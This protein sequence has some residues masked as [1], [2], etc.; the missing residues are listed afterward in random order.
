MSFK[1]WLSRGDKSSKKKSALEEGKA[2]N[3]NN[4]GR[5][6]DVKNGFTSEVPSGSESQIESFVVATDTPVVNSN[7]GNPENSSVSEASDNHLHI[8]HY[9]MHSDSGYNSNASAH[10][11]DSSFKHMDHSDESDL[12]SLFHQFPTI[13]PVSTVLYPFGDGS[14]KVFGYENFGNTCYC[15]SVLQCLYSLPELR[16]NMLKHP[17]RPSNI[18]R[19]RK[20]QMIGLKPRV[21]DETSFGPVNNATTANSGSTTLPNGSSKNPSTSSG[22]TASLQKENSKKNSLTFF[23]EKELPKLP[24]TSSNSAVVHSSMPPIATPVHVNVMA[25]DAITEKLHEGYT[26]IVVGRVPG[27]PLQVNGS[28]HHT[29]NSST[30]P[31]SSPSPSPTDNSHSDLSAKHEEPSSEQRKK[32]ALLKGPVLNVDHSLADYLPANNSPSLYAELKDLFEIITENNSLTGVV[33]PIQFVETLKKEN[34]LFNTMM[35]QDAHEFLNFLLNELSDSLTKSSEK[36]SSA[37]P[38]S[39]ANFIE[40]LF[41]GTMTNRTKCLTCDNVTYRNEP[42]LDFPIEVQ[43]DSETDI[44]MILSDFHQ[45]EM[46][47]GSNK[48]YCDECCGLQEAERVVGL[49]QL[50]FYLALHLKRFKYSEE[51]NCNIKLFNKIHYPAYLKVCSTFDSTVCKQYELV[52]VIVHM[53]GGPHHGHY[54]SLCKHEKFGWLLFDDETVESVTEGT[55]LKFIGDRDDLTTAYLLF[56]KDMGSKLLSDTETHKQQK[57]AQNIDDLIKADEQIRKRSIAT[58]ITDH[59]SV[60]EEVPEERSSSNKSLPKLGGKRKSRLFSFKRSSKD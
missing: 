31:G 1:R 20:T 5:E 59:S 41:K 27:S 54:V 34:V 38:N 15:N 12:D 14:N 25:S 8:N 21:F 57:F 49:K 16:V 35:H 39:N 55:V 45:K 56:Y 40:G 24:S 60:L 28:S 44:Q 4:E 30:S 42:F 32:A 47:N 6:A 58:P 50:P 13:K 11:F 19:K 9:H 33:S 46:L 29:H 48:F 52:G 43:E 18:P 3:A 10:T 36:N 51:Q 17:E 7:H 53:G 22:S 37:E 26:R 23:K 2:S